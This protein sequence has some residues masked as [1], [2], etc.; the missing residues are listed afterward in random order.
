MLKINNQYYKLKKRENNEK[1][2]PN[3]KIAVMRYVV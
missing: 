2:K 1:K 3:M